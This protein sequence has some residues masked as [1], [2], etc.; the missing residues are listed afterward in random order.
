MIK[1]GELLDNEFPTFALQLPTGAGKT[2]VIHSFLH[3]R[4]LK[5]NKNVLVITPSWEIA[6][7]H[8]MTLCQFFKD[9]AQR[10]SRLGG[11]GQII[12]AFDE[13]EPGMKGKVIITTSALFYARQGALRSKLPV[14]A[15]VIDEGHHGW[16]KKRLNSVQSFAR[17]L[18]IPS[19]LLTATPPQNME[20]LP[21][22]AQ[23]RYLDLVPD[24]LVECQVVR[25]ETGEEF[26]PVF[27][28][29]ALVQS[30]MVEISSRSRRFEKIV[31]DSI[32]L[33]KG[34][35]IY[36]AGSVR[37]AMGVFD[38]FKKHGISASVVHS[39]WDSK[40]D[41]INAIAIDRFRRG[42]VQ[43]LVNVQMLAMGF[44]V[45]NVETIIVARPVESDTL[46]TQMVGRGARPCEG[47]S[48]FI[49]IDV[50]DTIFKPDVAKIFEHKHLFDAGAATP[51]APQEQPP[52]EPAP[53][54][55]VGGFPWRN[56]TQ[57]GINLDFKSYHFF[58]S[59]ELLQCF[60]QAQSGG[61]NF[62]ITVD[63]NKR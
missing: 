12:S 61:S 31:A 33:M 15:I 63:E 38:A 60:L 3:Q 28:N 17:E 9:G 62:S 5:N 49:L 24:Y 57:R 26:N 25:L 55:A 41:K 44:D 34:Q 43:V 36:Y 1:L 40:A 50:H 59:Q 7:Q 42:Q 16:K 11:R 37:E 52:Q 22:A 19:I 23:L 48:K 27:R 21:F 35:T 4:F 8:A 6:N 13:F 54:E 51:P 47:K 2:F 56:E 14:S 30:S 32:P 46:F 20:A 53:I 45:P 18:K 39:Q 58:R 10:V 29:G